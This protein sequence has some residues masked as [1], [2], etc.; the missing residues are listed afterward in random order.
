[1]G[2]TGVSVGVDELREAGQ[3]GVPPREAVGE[4]CPTTVPRTG[5]WGPKMRHLVLYKLAGFCHTDKVPLT[6]KTR[7]AMQGHFFEKTLFLAKK[8][9][10]E[11]PTP[12]F[13]P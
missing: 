1:M 7:G 13:F 11:P 3:G 2:E 8:V 10:P 9:I 4:G 6:G 12:P 5:G